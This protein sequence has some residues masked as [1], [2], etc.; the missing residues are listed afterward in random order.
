MRASHGALAFRPGDDRFRHPP[1]GGSPLSFRPGR[2]DG[3][4]GKPAVRQ[5]RGLYTSP[6]ERDVAQFLGEPN[7][8]AGNTSSTS[9]GT[10]LG[11]LCLVGRK[12][13]RGRLTRLPELPEKEDGCRSPEQR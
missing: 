12:G 4:R 9:V 6:I 13:A 7:I 11:N 5:A 1:P 10:L 2:G 3:L 8:L